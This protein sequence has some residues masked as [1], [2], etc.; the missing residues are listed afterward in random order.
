MGR[1]KK[2]NSGGKGSG[3][4]GRWGSSSSGNSEEKS[5]DKWANAKE[6]FLRIAVAYE[7]FL[8]NEAELIAEAR[9]ALG[10]GSD[11]VSQIAQRAGFNFI[12]CDEEKDFYDNFPA[13]F[14]S[15]SPNT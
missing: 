9:E 10:L 12:Y 7:G 13:H 15:P 3:G 11:A 1:F 6:L 14:L 2:M 8:I 5:K 4:G